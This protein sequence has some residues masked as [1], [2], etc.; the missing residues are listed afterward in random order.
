MEDVSEKREYTVNDIFKVHVFDE[1]GT[2]KDI[3][4]FCAKT[5][6]ED[7]MAELFSDVELSLHKMN[8]VKFH[9]SEYIIHPDD[10]I[11]I[12]KKKI[13]QEI[14]KEKVAYEEI[15]MFGFMKTN[16][17]MKNIYQ[18]VSE[19]ETVEISKEKFQQIAIN[20]NT[21]SSKIAN[22]N[23]EKEYYTYDDFIDLQSVNASYVNKPIGLEFHNEYDFSFSANPFHI[24]SRL[25][26]PY[27]ISPKNQLLAF[28]NHLLLNYGKLDSNNI[29]V[30][31]I[32]SLYSY[33][34][35]V[36]IS[37][38]YIT[39]LYF[40]LLFNKGCKNEIDLNALHPK[41]IKETEKSLKEATLSFY[42]TV[43][44]FHEIYENKTEELPYIEKGIHRYQITMKSSDFDHPFPLDVLFKTIHSTKEMP[45]IK[46]NP[47]NRRENMYRFYSE[48]IAKNGKK[49]P[50]LSES[51]IM[52][53]SKE[54]GKSHQLSIYLQKT[55]NKNN[56]NIVVS[57]DSNSK[58]QLKGELNPPLSK[59][60]LE[61][62]I[63][64][65]INPIISMVRGHLYSSGYSLHNFKSL[66]DETIEI[67]N[68]KYVAKLTIDKKVELKKYAGCISGMFDILSDDVT[69][70]T[71]ARLRFKRVENFKEMDAQ[72][73]FITE[74]YQRAGD[75][76]E[77][78]ES[79]MET[80][81]LSEEDAELRLAQ[82]SSEHQQL[83]GRFLENP[84]F[85]VVFKMVPLKNDIVIEVDEIIH[86]DYIEI[87]HIYIDTI[88]RMTQKN[89]GISDSFL[90]R[91]KA[92]CSKS[93]SIKEAS[94][95]FGKENVVVSSGIVN[96]SELYKIQPLQFGKEEEVLDDDDDAGGI[97]FE[98][99]FDYEGADDED[100]QAEGDEEEGD[101]G[102]YEGG[103]GGNEEEKTDDKYV[104]N[105]D[106]MALKN[107]NPFLKMMTEREPSLF[108][109][110]KQGKFAL[111]SSACPFSDRRQPVILTDAEK[112]RI[113]E[114]SP[115]SYSH[116]LKY[117][118]DPEKPYWYICPRYWCLKTNS[119][120]S[121]ADVKAGKCGDIIPQNA[122]VV[123]K[124]A[125]VYE[126]AN[127]KEHFDK[128]GKYKTHVPSFL[129][130]KKHPNGLCIP[131]CFAK[132]W[133]SKQHKELR[134]KCDQD[135]GAAS[136]KPG[137][138]PVI[139]QSLYVM[140]PTILPLPENRWGFLPI[141]VQFFLGTDNSLAVTKQNSAL[142][143]PG[144]PCL[145][146]FGI[147]NNH[148]QSFIAIVAYYYAYKQN[149]D[150]IPRISE[151]RNILTNSIT[152]DMFLKYHNGNLVSIFRPAKIAQEDVDVD[153]HMDSEFSK[154]IDLNNEAQLDFFEETIAS[155]D[156]FIAFLRNEKSE[157]DHTYLWDII[158]DRNPKLMRDGLNIV[159]LEVM[160]SDITNNI[161]M[162][163]P[164]SAYSSLTYNPS[165]ETVIL[166][167]Q[168]TYFEPIHLYQLE[169]DNVIVKKAFLEHSA[170]KNVK[171]MLDL[172]KKSTQKYCHPLSSKPR[173]YTFKQNIIASE[174]ARILRGKHY[175]IG[176]QIINYNK[177]IIGLCVNK[178]EGQNF[179]FVPCYPS[180]I[181]EGIKIRY[182]D[183]D[184]IWLD[185]QTT[186]D[187]LN[188][189]A[190]DTEGKV[191]CQPKLKIMEDGMVVGFLT[192][193]NQFVQIN[194]PSEDIHGDG[195]KKMEH[196]DYPIKD[197]F[198]V[199][200]TLALTKSP[201]T[202]RIKT[203]HNITIESQFYNVF[204]SVVR[205]ELNEFENRVIRKQIQDVL[206]N[207]EILYHAKLAKI[208]KW[209]RELT[210][211]SVSFQI[212]DQV[213]IDAFKDIT[214]CNQDSD[215]KCSAD[216]SKRY[217]L[218]QDNGDGC[219]TIFPKQH[220]VSGIDNEKVY[221]GRVADEL[222]R[223]RRIRL[224]MFQTK[225]YLNITNKDFD[226]DNK[227]L[228]LLESLL[229]R[230][231][232]RD[233]APYNR[234]EFITNIHY[235]DAQP[236]E[237]QIYSSDLT[238]AEQ[239]AISQEKEGSQLD[240]YIL[241]CIRETKTK[242]VG[243]DKAGSWR[244]YF[245]AAAKEI[246]FMNSIVC[247]Y[248]PIIYILQQTLKAPISIQNVKTTLWN[249]YSK[250]VEVYR[251]KILTI[252]RNQGKRELVELVTSKKTTL[253]HLIFSDA[254][255]ITDLDLWI[256]CKVTQLP[257]VL[258]S[259][260]KLKYL[261]NH[262]DWLRIGS[263]KGEPNTK[264]Y[265]IRS[266]VDVA[267]N[268]PPAYQLV[269]P[270][271][272]FIEMKN[273]MFLQ[274]D[275]GDEAYIEN[276]QSIENFLA[277][278]HFITKTFKGK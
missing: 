166:I 80:Y 250:L 212:F 92:A 218:T 172:I 57:F 34:G 198:S 180:A 154:T 98:D 115:G 111:Y 159:I 157:I 243:N 35:K 108:L 174:L 77:V 9:F 87:L 262:I 133:D 205:I 114:T 109:T 45:L 271:Y 47:G 43:S 183:E 134:E 213:A 101:Q 228:F 196:H 17:N 68:F 176:S 219:K 112:K 69:S 209:L 202:D 25:T 55:F 182:M 275:R 179:V 193:T 22:V 162:I 235:D 216:S 15:Y 128:D 268:K 189:L 11:R 178:E 37:N 48:K 65:T 246:I 60:N 239:F 132:S 126:F 236:E 39:E 21:S 200:K 252:L 234:N 227:E 129:D 96:A 33:S 261:I 120:I 66:H 265:F 245:P 160:N 107:P 130:K 131:C 46:Y 185:Y 177:K 104:A 123:P 269:I 254:Y 135:V 16:V 165:K 26:T 82:Y 190:R 7:D 20:V 151:M 13:I 184:G 86:I 256:L 3:F 138:E 247:S 208:D 116:A 220:L 255:Y 4:I 249:G 263:G 197:K 164:S 272:S 41:L 173:V 251:D 142:I 136:V 54:I 153:K 225:T 10:S 203:I 253:E 226:I 194:P 278:Y 186:F 64:L 161:Q 72:Y 38:E 81:Q 231:Y 237:S 145:L 102:E 211:S 201:D 240:E 206:D 49:I 117:G 23:L 24:H 125:Y 79:L 167:K 89:R 140:S 276:I 56:Y 148:L 32:K 143:K 30:C 61:E 29:F 188:S 230:E 158:A 168:D 223:Y 97:Y 75:S 62:F 232:F 53:L 110:E 85:P 93:K 103:G 118:S 175:N 19:N 147:E 139:K 50:F 187:R 229:T 199:D 78:I 58:I 195:L 71:G 95:S 270:S 122:K 84:G 214:L 70:E 91:T 257:V 90:G 127:P 88:L 105:I 169:G 277:K 233:L 146:R 83:N 150:K 144:T 51:V 12:L 215:G 8:D 170:L 248:I 94:D 119:S 221:Y 141:P 222:L 113:D 137:T 274:A 14:G 121:E 63:G 124:G 264:Y 52:K 6:N 74:I 67:C 171:T 155:Y 273:T 99:D 242:V 152:L 210:K 44:L 181:L 59:D 207:H 224:F 76:K 238:L 2:V 163:C 267:P 5:K 100:E 73:S 258:F 18:K 28:E 266:P 241:D 244:P 156:N 217:C 191:L 36:G 149:L 42:K 260:T 31:D 192:E 1:T 106:G 259:S 27:E 204:R 40:P